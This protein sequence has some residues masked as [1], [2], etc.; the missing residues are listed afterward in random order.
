MKTTY[1]IGVDY[2]TDSVRSIV[3]DTANGDIVGTDVFLYPRWKL[4][5]YCNPTTNQFRQH[6]LDYLEGLESTIKN[7]L[8]KSPIGTAPEA[9][10]AKK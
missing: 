1:T 8:A 3:V 5:K 4:G 6:P 9:F 2:G 10:N 7:A